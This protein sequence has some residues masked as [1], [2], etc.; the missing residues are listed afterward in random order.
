MLTIEQLEERKNYIGASEAAAVLGLSRW[1]TPLSVWAEK[2]GEIDRE[3][4]SQK[5]HVKLGHL[6]EDDM[7]DLFMDETKKKLHRVNETRFHPVHKFLAANID[8]RVVGE[9]VPVELKT[10]NAFKSKEWDGEEIPREYIVQ[11]MHTLAVTGVPYCYLGVL[12]GNQDFQIKKVDRDEKLIDEMISR[13][14]AFWKGF[15]ETKIMPQIIM[16]DD[17]ET[18]EKLY[19]VASDDEPIMLSDRANVLIENLEGFKA[20]RKNLDGL[21]DQTENELKVMLGE[22]SCGMTILHKVSW[23]NSQRSHLNGDLLKK[24]LPEVHAKY[25]EVK[26][27][28]RFSVSKLT[29]VK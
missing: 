14:V 26:P 1:A 25:Y 22:K 5:L 24:D 16:K 27:V 4:I 23:K 2:V 9:N 12:I 28:R 19:P 6:L 15:V 8:R 29:E 3:D 10:C 7:S 20:D 11:C 17:G 18:I 21:I 13:E